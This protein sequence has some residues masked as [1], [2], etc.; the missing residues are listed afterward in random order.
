MPK[1]KYKGKG[2]S[3]KAGVRQKVGNGYLSSIIVTDQQYIR[4]DGETKPEDSK[5]DLRVAVNNPWKGPRFSENDILFLDRNRTYQTRL[6][7]YNPTKFDRLME[8]F[9]YQYIKQESNPIDCDG[10]L[11]DAKVGIQNQF[12][13]SAIDKFQEISGKTLS[14]SLI[15]SWQ[16]FKNGFLGVVKENKQI[17]S[18]EDLGSGFEMIFS[19][20]YSFY[21]SQQSKKQLIVLIDEP[22]LHLHP[23]LQEC[24][25]K[26]I[27]E[28][29]RSSQ[30]IITTHSPLFVKQ[31]LY[32]S[33]IKVNV[34]R[35]EGGTPAIAPITEMVLPYISSN[36]INYVAF[37][38]PTEEYHN[39][40]FEELKD[41]HGS[42]LNIKDF[43]INFFQRI[44]GETPN[45]PYNSI[46]NQVSIH[47]FLRTQIHHRGSVGSADIAQIE[48]S[49]TKM[50]GYF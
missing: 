22:E 44:K 47:S 23:K 40:L 31:A 12:I 6:G 8:D 27:L 41:I 29:S 48:S 16:P 32:N 45:Y 2:F 4:A 38:L 39:E 9:D 19:L 7:T 17:I 28:F 14:L 20:I 26:L 13:K 33:N 42:A 35:I 49:I 24:F 43:D 25:V 10:L 50:R 21:L 36:E 18:L 34:L 15:D 46:P 37:T 5:P 3:F 30:I 11:G 1:T